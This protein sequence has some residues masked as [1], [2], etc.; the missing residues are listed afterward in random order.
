MATVGKDLSAYHKS[1]LPSGGGLRV[2]VITSAWNT[3]ITEALRQGAFRT[4]LDLGVN[5]VD[6]VQESVPGSF[7]LPLGAQLVLQQHAHLDAVIC[8]GS[9]VQGETRHFEFVCQAVAQGVM[10][11]ALSH[12]VPVIFG[13]L[14]DDTLEQARARSGGALGNKGVEC[15]VAAVRMAALRARSEPRQ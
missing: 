9:V 7:E 4:L 2:A 3:E 14:T 1:D 6:I 5:E 13:V 11:V 8:L 10:N 15:A 12:S